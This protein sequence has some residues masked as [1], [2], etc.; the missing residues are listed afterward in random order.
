ME[1]S[2]YEQKQE[3]K[4]EFV[5]GLVVTIFLSSLLYVEYQDINKVA[6][7]ILLL[8]GLYGLVSVVAAPVSKVS[9]RGFLWGHYILM[10]V[11]LAIIYFSSFDYIF[12]LFAISNSILLIKNLAGLYLY[13]G[14]R[15]YF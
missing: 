4:F 5:I 1:K 15:E 10:S 9:E 11:Q 8:G 14:Q 13:R 2:L 12:E 3:K 6:Y 7:L